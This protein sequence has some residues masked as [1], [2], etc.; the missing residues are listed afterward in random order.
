[1]SKKQYEYF[2]LYTDDIIYVYKHTDIGNRHAFIHTYDLLHIN[3]NDKFVRM[4]N[5]KDLWYPTRGSEKYAAYFWCAMI[6]ISKDTVP[7][8]NALL[9][10]AGKSPFV[11]KKK[12]DE[13]WEY[14][15][16][17]A[18]YRNQPQTSFPWKD[19][20]YDRDSRKDLREDLK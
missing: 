17:A 20:G 3:G 6:P 18:R 14:R 12:P 16:E 13:L 11:F 19:G 4:A 9:E 5:K 15:V 7:V 2:I 1:M 8:I 10:S